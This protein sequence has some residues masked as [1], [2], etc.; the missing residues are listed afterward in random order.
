MGTRC[1][2]KVYDDNDEII[3]CLYRQYDGYPE[4]HGKELQAFINSG[5]VVNGIPLGD[6]RKLFNGIYDFSAQLVAHFKTDVGQ[7]YLYPPHTV[8][9]GEEYVYHVKIKNNKIKVTVQK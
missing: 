9:V 7:F 8:D 6:K 2:T 1:L 4:G 5:V 3:I